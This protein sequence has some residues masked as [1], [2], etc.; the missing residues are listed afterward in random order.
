MDINGVGLDA[1]VLRHTQRCRDRFQQAAA[2]SGSVY[3][4]CLCYC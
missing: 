2:N 1:V 4:Q 3:R